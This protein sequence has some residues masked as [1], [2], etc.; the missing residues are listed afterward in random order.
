MVSFNINKKKKSIRKWVY[1]I[2][3]FGLMFSDLSHKKRSV[4]LL[5]SFNHKGER[6]LL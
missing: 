1:F 5:A 6:N 2:L 3:F 4:H